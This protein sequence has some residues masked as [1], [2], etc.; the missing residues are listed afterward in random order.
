MSPEPNNPCRRGSVFV[1]DILTLLLFLRSAHIPL[2]PHIDARGLRQRT[3][4]ATLS[5]SIIS[6]DRVRSVKSLKFQ[7]DPL[8]TRERKR[9]NPS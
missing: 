5:H 6:D 1:F 4:E 8:L 3:V 7:T 9:R 2:T